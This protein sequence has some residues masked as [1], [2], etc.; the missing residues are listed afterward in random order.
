MTTTA[1]AAAPSSTATPA[2]A[3]QLSTPALLAL[4]IVPGALMTAGFVLFAPV[5]E[6]LG[7]PPIAALLAAIVLVLVPIELGVLAWTARHENAGVADLI[8]YRRH[9]PGRQWAILVPGLVLIAF[10]GLG[11][12]QAIE[13]ALID[14]FFGWLPDWYVS[15]IQVDRIGDYS[16]TVW[17]V[18][19]AAYLTEVELLDDRTANAS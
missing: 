11:L 6:T 15:P 4:H 1:L 5:V 8:P 16:A 17:I 18:T 9:M 19:L 2:E 13:P 14:R 3:S 7:F 10:L 12:H